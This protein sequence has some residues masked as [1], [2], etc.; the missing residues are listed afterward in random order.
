M[1]QRRP[2]AKQYT[3]PALVYYGKVES[4]TGGFSCSG[5]STKSWDGVEDDVS[6]YG[7]LGTPQCKD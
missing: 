3:P 7:F 5:I 6:T 4:I 2:P 1:N